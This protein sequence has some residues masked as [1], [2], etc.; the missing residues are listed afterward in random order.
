MRLWQKSK[1]RIFSQF[2]TW[3][4]GI[5]GRSHQSPWKCN[6][7][8]LDNSAR[9]PP[10]LLVGAPYDQ[11]VTRRNLENENHEAMR[12]KFEKRHVIEYSICHF[13]FLCESILIYWLLSTSSTCPSRKVHSPLFA[14]N[15]QRPLFWPCGLERSQQM[16]TRHLC[17]CKIQGRHLVLW[18]CHGGIADGKSTLGKAGTNP[19][20]CQFLKQSCRGDSLT[21]FSNAWHNWKLV[22]VSGTDQKQ[23]SNDSFNVHINWFNIRFP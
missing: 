15:F 21:W 8:G 19:L 6:F 16:S 14:H 20:K 4:A 2:C 3:N 13:L 23:N 10:E 5:N 11:S 22:N 12:R 18:V 1:K 17:P 9:L 7:H